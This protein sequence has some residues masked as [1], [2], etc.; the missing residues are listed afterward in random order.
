MLN[1]P[2][3]PIAKEVTSRDWH[4]YKKQEREEGIGDKTLNNMLGYINAVYNFL[5][6][7]AIIGYCNRFQPV[8]QHSRDKGAFTNCQESFRSALLRSGVRTVRGQASYVLRHTFASHFILY[9][10]VETLKY[11]CS[12]YRPW[13]LAIFPTHPL[14]EHAGPIEP[15]F[16][17]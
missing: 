1:A 10:A 14:G 9:S 15:I 11:R 16:R 5:S 8:K 2:L 6:R 17:S 3:I 12:P 13:H 4:R 7:N